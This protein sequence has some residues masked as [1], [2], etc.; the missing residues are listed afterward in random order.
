MSAAEVLL[1]SALA[2]IRHKGQQDEVE[3]MGKLAIIISLICF[4]ALCAS[5]TP[6]ATEPEL[7]AMCETLVELR[8]EIP[9][10]T[11]EEAIKDVEEDYAKREK[12]NK[13]AAV[14]EKEDWDAELEAGIKALKEKMAAQAED[15]EVEE[16]DKVTEED[17]QKLKDKIAAKKADTD[18]RYAERAKELPADKELGIQAAKEKVEKNKALFAEEVEECMVTA[19]KEPVPQPLAKC[20]AEATSTDQFWNVCK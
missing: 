19:R 16:E 5:C 13:R 3:P 2:R 11:E 9:T 17:I 8:G 1:E 14:L 18:K 7:R 20:R 4:G 10:L 15:D 6:D 12:A